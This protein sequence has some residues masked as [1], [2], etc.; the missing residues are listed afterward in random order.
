MVKKIFWTDTAKFSL[1]IIFDY[2]K[3]NVSSLIALK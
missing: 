1:K 2:Y 3:K